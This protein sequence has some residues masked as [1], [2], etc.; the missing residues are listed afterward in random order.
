MCCSATHELP[1]RVAT[2]NLCSDVVMTRTRTVLQAAIDCAWNRRS[3][4]E[5][6]G[7][8]AGPRTLIAAMPRICCHAS[9]LGPRS[10]SKQAVRTAG[11]PRDS[12]LL[13]EVLDGHRADFNTAFPWVSIFCASTQTSKSVILAENIPY[14][15]LRRKWRRSNFP[16]QA[17]L[18]ATVR[19]ETQNARKPRLL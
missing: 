15:I 19:R 5:W 10:I 13:H 7:L 6:P 1:A 18:R 14:C 16:K 8:S 2:D 11:S 3:L 4:H 17:R 12:F 9:M